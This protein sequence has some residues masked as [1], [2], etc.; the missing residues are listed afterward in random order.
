VAA[1]G[2]TVLSDGTVLRCILG[3]VGSRRYLQI[4][5]VYSGWKAEYQEAYSFVRGKKRTAYSIAFGS[6]QLLRMAVDSGALNLSLSTAQYN[7]GRHSSV[8][9]LV[10]AHKLSMPWSA[11]VVKGAVRAG[12]VDKY[13][14]LRRKYTG[15][16]PSGT[17]ELAARSNSVDILS[18]LQQEGLQVTTEAAVQAIQGGHLGVLQFLHAEGCELND[19]EVCRAA[20]N[21]RDAAIFKW[22]H[23]IGCIESNSLTAML[24][25]G[26]GSVELMQY[27]QQYVSSDEAAMRAAVDRGQLPM[28]RYLYKQGLTWSPELTSRALRSTQTTDVLEWALSIL[29]VE[30]TPEQQSI[31]DTRRLER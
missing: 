1:L 4:A 21:Q 25:A 5:S 29:G 19:A 28:C 20:V 3:Y 13:N 7:A 26:G 31:Y 11:A 16:L 9:V 24:V 23:S 17:V 27:L 15:V 10:L 6:P 18:V 2:G 14:W 22:L 8:A 12:C 30:L